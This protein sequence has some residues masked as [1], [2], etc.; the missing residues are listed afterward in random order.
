MLFYTRRMTEAKTFCPKHGT[1]GITA[2]HVGY[3]LKDG[4]QERVFVCGHCKHEFTESQRY[5][6]VWGD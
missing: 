5:G 1:D 2:Y 3:E 6:T 4:K